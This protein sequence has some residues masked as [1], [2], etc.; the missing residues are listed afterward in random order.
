[1]VKFSK[2]EIGILNKEIN[3]MKNKYNDIKFK[4]INKIET[5]NDVDSNVAA[6][7]E[8]D[9]NNKAIPENDDE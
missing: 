3:E 9:F 2:T 4:L 1:M 5:L 7:I 8:S 6:L